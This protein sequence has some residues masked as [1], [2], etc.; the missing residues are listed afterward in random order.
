MIVRTH[1]PVEEEGGREGGRVIV[2]D[3]DYDKM[4]DTITKSKESFC[5][6]R[7]RI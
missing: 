5:H 3:G 2:R 7:I 6:Q 1:R 4:C